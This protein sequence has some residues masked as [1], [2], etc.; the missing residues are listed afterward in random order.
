MNKKIIAG[1]V[2]F[3]GI[4]AFASVSS[5]NPSFFPPTVQTGAATTSVAYLAA[6][7]GNTTLIFDSY[8]TT[9][10]TYKTDKATL[11]LQ[12]AASSTSSVFNVSFQFSQDGIDYYA[13]NLDQG[14]T[15]TTSRNISLANSYVWTAAGTATSSKA[16]SITT[17]TRYVKAIVSVS[18]AAGAVWQQIVPVKEKSE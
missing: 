5:A 7:S 12:T 10:S 2:G 13:D 17:P 8:T 18:G 14:A 6:G 9:G 16:I 3:I 1:I 11:L 15:T 4:L